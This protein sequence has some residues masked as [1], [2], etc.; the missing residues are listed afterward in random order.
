MHKVLVLTLSTQKNGKE[1]GG[2]VSFGTHHKTSLENTEFPNDHLSS[3]FF[4]LN[5]LLLLHTIALMKTY[6][7]IV[8]T[9]TRIS[10][11]AFRTKQVI[12]WVGG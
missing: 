3:F 2:R 9:Q 5:D 4:F 10:N 1:K 7:Q 11:H 12:M 6:E 8:S